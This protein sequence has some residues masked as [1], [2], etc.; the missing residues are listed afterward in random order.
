L[1]EQTRRFAFIDSGCAHNSARLVIEEGEL[2]AQL[3]EDGSPEQQTDCGGLAWFLS[4][5]DVPIDDLPDPV[6]LP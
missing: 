5:F 3:L 1:G 4:V 6:R 2:T